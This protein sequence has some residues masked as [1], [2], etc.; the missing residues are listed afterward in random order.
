MPFVRVWIH[1]VWSTKNRYPYLEKEIRNHLFDHIKENARSKGIFLDRLN[2][3]LD[4]IHCLISLDKEQNISKTIQ[5]IKG[6]SSFWI[7]KNSLVNKKFQWQDE[8]FAV[9]VSE[10]NLQAVRDYIDS[11]EI[12]H[13]KKTFQEEYDEFIEKYNFG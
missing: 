5:F 8:Y 13:S 12:H 3:Y 9:S 7:N 2:G 1:A 11:Q 10:S 4:H 6:E